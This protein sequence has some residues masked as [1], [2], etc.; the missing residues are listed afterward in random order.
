LGETARVSTV[1]PGPGVCQCGGNGTSVASIPSTLALTRS[2]PS[3]TR[4]S[5]ILESGSHRQIP[6]VNYE[7]RIPGHP[8]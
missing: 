6:S 8:A 5:R 4:C 7:S 3:L 1:S 2:E